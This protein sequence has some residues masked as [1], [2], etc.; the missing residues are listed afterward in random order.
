MFINLIFQE[1]M[2]SKFKKVPYEVGDN[3]FVY[4]RFFHKKNPLTWTLYFGKFQ[5]AW[6]KC[7]GGFYYVSKHKRIIFVIS[8]TYLLQML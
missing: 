6:V 7:I 8:S 3:Y 5:N 4:D 1:N 2:S